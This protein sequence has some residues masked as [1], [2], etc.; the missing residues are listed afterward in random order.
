MERRIGVGLIGYGQIAD[1][2]LKQYYLQPAEVTLVACAEVDKVQAR[3]LSRRCRRRRIV[4]IVEELLGN[5]DVDAVDICTPPWTHA[6]LIQMAAGA[7]K[8]IICEKPLAP[9]L[10][11]AISAV[12][13]A[14]KASVRFGVMQNYRFRP[15]YVEAQAL[16]SGGAIGTPFMASVEALYDWDGGENYRQRADRLLIFEQ[17]YH[18]IDTLR[19]LLGDDIVS[20][21]AANGHAESSRDA[22]RHVG[23]VD[24]PLRRRR[25]RDHRELRK[26]PGLPH[27]LGW[28]GCHPG[29]GWCTRNQPTTALLS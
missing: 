7:G 20:V 25:R 10:E 6:N 11:E 26:L 24:P 14:E 17:T 13:A 28:Y 22:W 23:H 27:E 5:A 16:L 1:V 4:R 2:H 15:E 21:Y 9:S 3:T 18:Y 8:H 29:Y 19:F 12:E